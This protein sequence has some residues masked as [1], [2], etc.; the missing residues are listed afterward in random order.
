RRIFGFLAKSQ[1]EWMDIWTKFVLRIEAE[2]GRQNC[3]GWIL[4][5]NGAVY[6]SAAMAAFCSSKGIQQRFSAPYAQWMNHSAERNM[7]TIGEMTVT[8]MIHANMPKNSWG[9]AMLHAIDVFNRT[10]DSVAA[11]SKECKANS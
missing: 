4:S 5:D 1:T 6:K 10:T 2:L 8:T 9:Y 11:S 7:R 3:I